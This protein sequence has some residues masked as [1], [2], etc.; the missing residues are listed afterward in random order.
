MIPYD[1]HYNCLLV[2][3]LKPENGSQLQKLDDSHTAWF[4]DPRYDTWELISSF[5]TREGNR[6][7]QYKL[8]LCVRIAAF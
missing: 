2:L 5:T 7:N 4:C 8:W 1:Y 3:S 6:C